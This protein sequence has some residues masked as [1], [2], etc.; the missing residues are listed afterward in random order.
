MVLAELGE[1]I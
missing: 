1:Q